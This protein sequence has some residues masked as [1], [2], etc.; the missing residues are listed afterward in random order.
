MT[1]T[2]IYQ[3][4]IVR[5]LVVQR[6][7][8][9]VSRLVYIINTI[10]GTRIGR[11]T[12]MRW[13]RITL[14][15]HSIISY[16]STDDSFVLNCNL[17]SARQVDNIVELCNGHIR[18]WLTKMNTTRNV[19]NEHSQTRKRKR[20]ITK[21]HVTRSA[22]KWV[23]PAIEEFLNSAPAAKGPVDTQTSDKPSP[24]RNTAPVNS[25]SGQRSPEHH[26]RKST[27][28]DKSL[29]G[30][31]M[32]NEQLRHVF[33][34]LNADLFLELAIWRKEKFCDARNHLFLKDIYYR[35]QLNGPI[36][37]SEISRVF[38]IIYMSKIEGFSHPQIL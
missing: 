37:I 22:K 38:K 7:R 1:M 29:D 4:I 36:R 33:S 17:N 14:M 10:A 19:S 31:G 13:P 28:E 21:M 8:C 5:E 12:V 20:C 3:P 34:T 6:G 16:D 30:V 23:N 9:P 27:G 2:A 18:K 32:R 24:P 35:V 11:E 15:R 25:R 26:A